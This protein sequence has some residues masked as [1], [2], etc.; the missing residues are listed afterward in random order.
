MMRT[1]QAKAV[2]VFFLSIPLPLLL[3]CA[4]PKPSSPRGAAWASSLWARLVPDLAPREM[5]R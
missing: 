5:T 2:F 4:Q 1:I 3:A